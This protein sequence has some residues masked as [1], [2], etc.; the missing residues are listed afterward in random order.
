MQHISLSDFA[1][2]LNTIMPLIMKEFAKRLTGELYKGNITLPQFFI[3]ESL[4]R[5]GSSK[6]TDLA[7]CMNVTTAAMTGMVDRLVREGYAVRS[8]DT[9]DRRIINVTLTPEGD[10]LVKRIGECR[11]QM[12]I[13]V[14]GKMS[15]ED[16]NN[17][18][19]IITQMKDILTGE[20]P[21]TK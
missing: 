14:F 12:A 8:H 21:V 20:P 6:M 2:K 4:H 9:G 15:E 19:R 10:T 1:D 18:L 13:K 17:Y 7:R 11:R 5:E 3:M 16:R